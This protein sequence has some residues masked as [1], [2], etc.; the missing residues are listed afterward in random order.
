MP[1]ESTLKVS[2]GPRPNRDSKGNRRR[3]AANQMMLPELPV[4]SLERAA[5]FA[6]LGK[7]FAEDWA[8]AE[9]AV[10]QGRRDTFGDLYFVTAGRAVKI[11]RTTNFE[12]RLCHIQAHNHEQVECVALLKG[13]GWRE[14]DLHAR[15]CTR[16]LRGEWF[17]RCP[18]IEAEIERLSHR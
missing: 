1:T 9:A 13:Q 12:K 11:G 10:E 7:T 14:K 6:E 15:F 18:E 3:T 17:A 8:A 4:G 2:S 5:V 16:R